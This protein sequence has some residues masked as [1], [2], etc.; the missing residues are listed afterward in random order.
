MNGASAET[1]TEKLYRATFEKP[2]TWFMDKM[3]LKPGARETLD[4]AMDITKD[5]TLTG[6]HN[7]QDHIM[8]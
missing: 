4:N 3:P 5:V 2:I 8:A 1:L 6:I 7:L